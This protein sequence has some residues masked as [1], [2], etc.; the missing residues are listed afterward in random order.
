MASHTHAVAVTHLEWAGLASAL[1]GPAERSHSHRC[2]AAAARS[3]PSKLTAP[4]LQ[5]ATPR[6]VPCRP[7]TGLLTARPTCHCAS[8]GGPCRSRAAHAQH[9]LRP[10]RAGSTTTPSLTAWL[11]NRGL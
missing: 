5:H 9:V 11:R 6:R 7:V 10:R 2:T 4:R 3:A 1:P 8:P